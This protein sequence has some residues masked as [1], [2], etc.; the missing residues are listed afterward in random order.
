M[1]AMDYFTKHKDRNSPLGVDVGPM[2]TLRVT[3]HPVR[4]IEMGGEGK[5]QM[6]GPRKRIP[7]GQI[8]DLIHLPV[9]RARLSQTYVPMVAGANLTIHDIDKEVS[10]RPVSVGASSSHVP[11]QQQ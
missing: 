6:E 10:H 2:C 8:Q 1:G 3:C 11:P 4:L 5:I 9:P 7:W